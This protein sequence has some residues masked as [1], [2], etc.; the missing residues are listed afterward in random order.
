MF[1]CESTKTARGRSHGKFICCFDEIFVV[2]CT[3]SAKKNFVLR[4]LS[5]AH[6]R[7][8]QFAAKH[9]ILLPFSPYRRSKPTK[10]KSRFCGEIFVFPFL[11]HNIIS[12][13]W[14]KSISALKNKNLV[15][16]FTFTSSREVL[17]DF[18]QP[19]PEIYRRFMLRGKAPN[20]YQ[21]RARRRC[22]KL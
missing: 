3:Q 1:S 14:A 4:S 5:A 18:S 21:W 20:L 7:K 16:S 8:N 12:P 22:C 15:R 19:C 10:R 9:E 6:F 13:Y 11:T 2:S 17:L